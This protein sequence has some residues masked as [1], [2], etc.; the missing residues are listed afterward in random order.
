MF[1]SCNDYVLVEI[2]TD[3]ASMIYFLCFYFYLFNK[4]IYF[5]YFWLC[6]VFVTAR[7]LSLVEA[8]GGYSS[9]R[10]TC[11]SLRWLLLL[12]S[13]GFRRMGFSSCGT[14]A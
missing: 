12:R 1:E 14:W 3:T 9:L 13:T 11:F 6:W 5:I 8:R 4:F 10:C 7:R 2:K